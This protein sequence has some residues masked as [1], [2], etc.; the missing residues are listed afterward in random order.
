MSKTECFKICLLIKNDEEFLDIKDSQELIK[1]HFDTDGKINPVIIVADPFLYVHNDELYLFYEEKRLFTPGILRMV[2]TKDLKEWTKPVTVLQESFHLS[3]PYVFED[4][5]N[6]YMIPETCNAKEIRLY[7][8]D[9]DKLTHFSQVDVLVSHKQKD[10]HITID[11]SD[12]SVLKKD[13]TYYLMTTL[14]IDNENQ[15]FLY[16][17]NKLEGPYKEH[18]ASPIC[19]SNKFG[20]N[21]GS[22]IQRGEKFYRVA[23]DCEKRYGDN[24]HLF[25]VKEMNETTYH[26]VLL[27]ENLYD[28]SLPFYKEGGHQFNIIEFNGKLIIATDAKEYHRFLITKLINKMK[29][30]I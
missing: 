14:E 1:I 19:K 9:N 8:A 23:Q 21:A 30:F 5:G 24:V 17:S 20:R 4:D 2:K 6:V 3:Y 26:E 18:L 7:I 27:K 22:L 28:N 12:S 15:L 13:N 25:E 29:R 16:T 11:Y 10:K